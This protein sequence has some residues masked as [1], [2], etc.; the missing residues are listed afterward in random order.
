[1]APPWQLLGT[2]FLGQH[3]VDEAGAAA[4]K[5]LTLEPANPDLI[6][7][8]GCVASERGDLAEAEAHFRRALELKPTFANALG[9][10]G[11]VLRR[12]GQA[13]RGSRQL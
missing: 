3:K 11:N 1:M 7:L 5:G 4:E 13:G 12:P 8:A 2:L 9:N 6:N 10:F